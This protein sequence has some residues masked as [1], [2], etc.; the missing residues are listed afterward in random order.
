M[1]ILRWLLIST[2]F[3]STMLWASIGKVSLLK[4]EAHVKRMEQTS[5]LHNGALLEE[6]DVI[7][8]SKN[9]QMQLIF[10]DKTVVTLGSESE[11]KIEEYLNDATKPKSKFKFNQGTF[12]TITGNIGKI[13]PENVTLETKTATIGIRGTIVAGEVGENGDIIG[14]LQGVIEVMSLTGGASVIVREGQQTT[15]EEGSPAQTPKE[16]G[17]DQGGGGIPGNTEDTPPS[18]E[19]PPSAD[20]ASQTN[21]QEG[22]LED[23][24]DK[25]ASSGC[26]AGSVGTASRCQPINTDYELPAY[27]TANLTASSTNEQKTLQGYATG[28]YFMSGTTIFMTDGTLFLVIDG[29]SETIPM[30][31]A[32]KIYFAN[33]DYTVA[34]NKT[35]TPNETLTYKNINE[36]SVNNFDSGIDGWI[37]SE[38]TLPNQYVSWGYWQHDEN[39]QND[40]FPS[41]NFW[42]AGVDTEGAKTHITN[43]ELLDGITTTYTYTGKSIG[44]VHD[45]ASNS[46]TGIDAVNNNIVS[47]QFDFGSGTPLNAASYIQFQ[48]NG[49]TP[50]VWKFDNLLLPDGLA[51]SGTS[52]IFDA[53]STIKIN[54]TLVDDTQANIKGTFYG[55]EAQAVGGS[56][57]APTGN[58]TAIGVF[59]AV[60]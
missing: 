55:S 26:P 20:D 42:V 59:K 46:Y 48:T 50:E 53:T 4:G 23:V 36:F 44:Y 35:A 40:L 45:S 29:S 2:L 5:A 17:A 37:Q 1:F 60:R 41:L 49:T 43:L 31:A 15:V 47:L 22:T 25:V 27:W 54:G 39:N 33:T 3:F 57:K 13:A 24:N 18:D 30:I 10:E 7:V 6:K 51:I 34:L 21:L 38:N 11:F 14:C 28:S 32:S 9:T 8:T 12:K 16:M 52:K 58:K 19:T 56:F